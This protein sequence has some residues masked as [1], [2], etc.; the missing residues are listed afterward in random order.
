MKWWGAWHYIAPVIVLESYHYSFIHA[1]DVDQK[2]F[3]N[4]DKPWLTVGYNRLRS[5]NGVYNYNLDRTYV[6]TQENEFLKA[7][8]CPFLSLGQN[9]FF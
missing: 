5:Q 1:T 3:P 2:A 4:A 9:V 6:L 7:V 8:W